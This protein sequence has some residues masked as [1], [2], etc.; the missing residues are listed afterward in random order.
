MDVKRIVITLLLFCLAELT[1]YGQDSLYA[2]QVIATLSSAE[3]HGRGYAFK[4]DSIAAEYIRNEY[5]KHNLK[6]L[7]P[8]YYQYY[9]VPITIYDN[10]VDADFGKS[11]PSNTF[12]DI[13]QIIPFSPSVKGTFKI[14]K[15]SK[16]MLGHKWDTEKTKDKFVCVDMTLYES[17]KEAKREWQSVIYN[18]SLRAKGYILLEKEIPAFAPGY[19]RT[20]GTYTLIHLLKDSVKH[21]LNQ[22]TLNINST[23]V[24]RYNTQNICGYVEGKL[25]PDTFFVI[26][27]HYDHVG[28]MGKKHYFPGANDNASGTAMLLDLARYYSLPE[29]QPDYSIAFLAFSG[30]EIGLMGSTYYVKHPLF[31]LENIKIMLNLDMVG[32]GEEGF[33]F[34]CGIP[35]ADEYK[36]FEAL[37]NEKNYAPK[38]LQREATQNSD[39]YPFYNKGCKALF[40]YGMGKSGEYHHSSDTLENLSLGGYNNLFRILVDYINLTN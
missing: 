13:L 20:K 1:V 37:N 16:K 14:V 31:P 26:G 6:A 18:N 21:S 33:A 9:N 5:K 23:F 3:F 2:R 40:I 24:R 17:D 8:N 27:A 30:E 32:T 15:A 29:N 10:D 11:Y 39:H 35:F 28:Q 4:G 22:V 19:G 36:K 25:Y 7:T 38:L 12:S 34:V